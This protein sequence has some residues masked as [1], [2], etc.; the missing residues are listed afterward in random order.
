MYIKATNN[1]QNKTNFNTEGSMKITNL[2]KGVDVCGVR[3]VVSD[4]IFRSIVIRR[5]AESRPLRKISCA[6]QNS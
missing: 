2:P 4:A 5:R 6:L 1:Q 3:S